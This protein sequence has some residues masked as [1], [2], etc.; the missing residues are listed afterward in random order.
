MAYESRHLPVPFWILVCVCLLGVTGL[1]VVMASLG[2]EGESPIEVRKVVPKEGEVLS[3]I[4][5]YLV[6]FLGLD[7]S[8][9]DD[10][11]AF[12]VF[13]AVLGV[14]YVN[15]NMLFVNPLL[16]IVGYHTYEIEDPRE[17]VFT[18]LTR[19][20]NLYDGVTITPAQVDP[21]LR[22]DPTWRRERSDETDGG[23]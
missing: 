23:T 14:I 7:L 6:P 21:Y 8:K 13:L 1:V 5:V 20:R 9:S 12:C 16:S 10:V 17:N 4:A 2:S 22:V 15:S 3:Y 11:V 19:Q 18:V